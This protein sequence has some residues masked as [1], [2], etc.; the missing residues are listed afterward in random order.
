MRQSLPVYDVT[1]QSFEQDVIE[2][3]RTVPVVVDFW[4]PWCGPCRLLGPVLESLVRS[5]E[6]RVELAKLNT[7]EALNLSY[8]Y[9][10]EAIPAVKGFR[11]GEVVTEFTGVLPE[12]QV[13]SFLERLLPSEADRLAELAVQQAYRGDTAAA[14]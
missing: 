2:R 11:D 5:Y 6:G 3:S 12:P 8:R 10:I 9:G 13:R 1:E 14:E 7:D 4:A